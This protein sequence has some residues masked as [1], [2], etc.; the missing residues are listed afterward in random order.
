MRTGRL[1]RRFIENDLLDGMAVADDP[2]AEGLLDS[3][4]I[5]Q[6]VAFAE[7]RFE[8]SFQDEELVQEHFASVDA[9]ARLVD[10]K[11]RG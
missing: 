3:L 5:E 4:A 6:L 10:R 7:D 2:L 11:R 9:L 8:I 1:L